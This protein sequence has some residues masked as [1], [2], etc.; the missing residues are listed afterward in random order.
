MKRLDVYID[1]SGDLSPYRKTNQLY[2]VSFVL[3]DDPSSCEGALRTF[4][5]H[6]AKSRS[7]AKREKSRKTTLSH[8]I[9]EPFRL[10]V[11]LA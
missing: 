6:K 10:G 4:Y 5:I 8:W 1:E 9:G 3:C 7:S 11:Y 2:A